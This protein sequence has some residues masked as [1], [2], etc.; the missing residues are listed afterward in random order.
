MKTTKFSGFRSR[1]RIGGRDSHDIRGAPGGG[2]SILNFGKKEKINPGTILDKISKND[3]SLPKIKDAGLRRQL[4]WF[5]REEFCV[6][7]EKVVLIAAA[8]H[9]PVP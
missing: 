4:L 9:H 5:I 6:A 1:K 7:K 3:L 2:Y 8:E